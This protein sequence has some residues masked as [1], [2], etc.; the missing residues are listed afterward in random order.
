MHPSAEEKY[1]QTKDAKRN[2][3]AKEEMGLD[4]E[5]KSNDPYVIA[6]EMLKDGRVKNGTFLDGFAQ[7]NGI[8]PH[9]FKNGLRKKLQDLGINHKVSN[10]YWEKKAKEKESGS[11]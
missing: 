6:I 4:D 10:Y 1:Q 3:V 5:E 8:K 9:T 11:I 7:A 2:L